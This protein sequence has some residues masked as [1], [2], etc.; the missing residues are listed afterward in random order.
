MAEPLSLVRR[1]IRALAG[2]TPGE[3]VVGALKLNTNECAW[4]PSPAA[5]EAL[6]TVAAQAED[7]LRLY[8]D[9]LS[10]SL[11]RAA[12]EVYG[13]GEDQVLAGNGSDDCLTVLYRAHLGPADHV[14]VPSPTYGLYDTLAGLQ[15][16]TIEHAPW[17]AGWELPLEDLAESGARL[18]I[19]ANPNNPSSTLV[20]CED[21]CALAERLENGI[22]VVDEA[23][24]D[25]AEVG[26]QRATM[27]RHLDSH[28]NV[29]VLRS[30]SKSY[31]LA[32]ARLGL[33]FAHPDLV[34]EY[35][36]VKD[37]YNLDVVAQ[38]MGTAALR[39]RA[40][41][42]R[43]VADTLAGR[44]EL[45]SLLTPLGWTWPQSEANFLLCEVGD[46][47]QQVLGALRDRGLLVRWWDT[48][49]LRRCLRITVGRPEHHARLITA[50]R[51]ILG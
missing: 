49:Q 29:V 17:A 32:G 16:V 35:R 31:S 2:Y 30:F 43:V 26:G 42:H 25:F 46:N 24:I 47:A 23:Y 50:L 37:S 51:G 11:C 6:Q 18:V 20:P 19:V 5:L 3:Q 44:Q 39:D 12:S 40:Y 22:L 27:L 13:V 15:G 1:E 10:R 48:P 34:R 7:R 14:C 36:K 33:L 28:P 4:G 8:P 41:H 9:P 21:L 45:E 38:A